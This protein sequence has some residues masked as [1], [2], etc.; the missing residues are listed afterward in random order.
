MDRCD[1]TKDEVIENEA[2]DFVRLVYQKCEVDINSV[3]GDD[4][5][6]GKMSDV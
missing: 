4:G 6:V 1:P 5:K 3:T 2:I